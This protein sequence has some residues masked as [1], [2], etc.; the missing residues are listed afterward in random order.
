MASESTTYDHIIKSPACIIYHYTH[1]I[2]KLQLQSYRI[3]SERGE[4][5]YIY[6]QQNHGD[7]HQHW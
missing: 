6:V 2:R 5:Q 1:H 3:C 7:Y 4:G